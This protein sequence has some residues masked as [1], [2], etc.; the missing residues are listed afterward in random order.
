[1]SQSDLAGKLGIT[2]QAVSKWENGTNM[3]DMNLLPDIAATL[4]ITIDELFS[5]PLDR[6]LEKIM[7]MIEYGRVLSNEEFAREEGFLLRLAETDPENYEAISLL[8]D[9]YRHQ[10][11]CMN[12]KCAH[13]ARQAL[14]LK[15]NS[16][17]DINNINNSMHGKLS[18]WTASNHRELIDYWKDTLRRR[19]ENK[20]LYL[21]LMD[22]LIPSPT[23]W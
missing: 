10:A 12:R 22:S 16:K 4:G 2:S 5:Y 6:H 19:P 18:D 11:N 8:G 9:L 21:Y 1:M 20:S 14:E 17:N 13:Y 3:P 23:R 7:G 15:P